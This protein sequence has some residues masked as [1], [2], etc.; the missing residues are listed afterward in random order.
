MNKLKRK[1]N[2]ARKKR[3]SKVEKIICFDIETDPRNVIIS[4]NE[5][6]TK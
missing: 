2:N 6:V 1:K 5:R 3:N 4:I